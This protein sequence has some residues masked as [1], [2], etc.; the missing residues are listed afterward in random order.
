MSIKDRF[1]KLISWNSAL[2]IIIN[3]LEKIFDLIYMDVDA[4]HFKQLLK[5]LEIKSPVLVFIQV[6]KNFSK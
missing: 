6:I 3:C 1:N 5:M 4:I 2:T